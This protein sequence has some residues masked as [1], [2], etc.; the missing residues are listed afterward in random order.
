[1]RK[2]AP[3]GANR[4]PTAPSLSIEG[5]DAPCPP[6]EG[7]IARGVPATPQVN[8][9]AIDEL[10]PD[11]VTDYTTGHKTSSVFARYDQ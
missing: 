9:C 3:R 2:G 11:V 10:L 8:R 5:R 1:M 6:V 4:Y 7:D